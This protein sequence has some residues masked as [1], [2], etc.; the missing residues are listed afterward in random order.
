METV[1]VWA[2]V[3][4]ST[5]LVGLNANAWKNTLRLYHG[6][7]VKEFIETFRVLRGSWL[8]VTVLVTIAVLVLFIALLPIYQQFIPGPLLLFMGVV[9]LD[10]INRRI[11]PPMVLVL[12]ASTSSGVSVAREIKSR[13]LVEIFGGVRISML[14]DARV[15]GVLALEYFYNVG[16]DNLRQRWGDDWTGAVARLMRIVPAII[17]DLRYKTDAMQV[18]LKLI[19][20]QKL[21]GKT[22]CLV[23]PFGKAQSDTI[24]PHNIYTELVELLD[25]VAMNLSEKRSKER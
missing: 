17:I 13:F 10:N 18:E 19:R 5:L 11:M 12:C 9:F 22:F 16:I 23:E 7:P 21:L 2:A 20:D 3:I 6:V 8:F 25:Q 4:F 15:S 24:P 1:M 14:L